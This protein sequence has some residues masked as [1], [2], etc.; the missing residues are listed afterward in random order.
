VDATG[1]RVLFTGGIVGVYGGPLMISNYVANINS[2][3]YLK[4]LTSGEVWWVSK[5]TNST[6]PDAAFSSGGQAISADGKV[7][8]FGSTGAKFVLE[9]TDPFDNTDPWDL[10]RVDIGP[11]GGLT[12]TLISKPYFGTT[13]VS[14]VGNPCLTANGS[15]VA[16]TSHN[17][18]GL[19]GSGPLQGNYHGYGLGTLPAAV[20]LPPPPMKFTTSPGQLM[21]SWPVTAGVSLYF[22]T[23]LAA[24]VWTPATNIPTVSNGTNTVTLNPAGPARFYVLRNP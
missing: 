14:V 22:K 9:N 24:A 5:T 19:T 10:F 7:V 20:V 8:A 11:N 12:N 23:N 1:N 3:L 4:D 18:N 21:L 13:N 17:Q 2:D 15:Y 16:F 6:T